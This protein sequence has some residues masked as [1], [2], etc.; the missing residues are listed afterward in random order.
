ML[1]KYIAQDIESQLIPLARD[2]IQQHVLPEASTNADLIIRSG[3]WKHE[4]RRELMELLA[5]RNQRFYDDPDDALEHIPIYH[6]WGIIT[7]SKKFQEYFQGEVFSLLKK[8]Q[9]ESSVSDLLAEKIDG[10]SKRDLL[11]IL[12]LAHDTGKFQVRNW[13]LDRLGRLQANFRPHEEASGTVI[14]NFIAPHLQQKYHFTPAQTE[15]IARGAELHYV[16]GIM[17]NEAKKSELGYNFRFLHS[18][19]FLEI[20]E[21]IIKDYHSFALEIGLL[22]LGDSLAKNEFR[23]EAE[24]DEEI[25][26][27]QQKAARM[28]AEHQPPL[29]PELVFAV[30]QMPIN[31]KVVELYLKRFMRTL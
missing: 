24:T 20:V 23:L 3:R 25:Q 6:Q 14:R 12:I 15:Y 11:N 18:S 9:I 2:L 1:S 7:H 28:L 10:I 27:Q 8:W 5:A 19:R 4:Q 26:R 17:R 30:K 21:K 13:R 31:I 22:F 16:L 29:P